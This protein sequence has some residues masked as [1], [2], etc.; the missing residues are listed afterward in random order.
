MGAE[1]KGKKAV[2]L[3]KGRPS[4]ES[5]ELSSPGTQSYVVNLNRPSHGGNSELAQGAS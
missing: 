2:S 4:L 1:E 5:A 3:G